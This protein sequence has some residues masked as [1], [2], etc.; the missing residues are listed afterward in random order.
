MKLP[1]RKFSL[2]SLKKIT[3]DMNRPLMRPFTSDE[4][5]ISLK[6]MG[7]DKCSGVDLPKELGYGGH[8]CYSPCSGHS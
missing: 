4:V 3:P 7:P 2:L 5:E 6:S 8:T 1:S